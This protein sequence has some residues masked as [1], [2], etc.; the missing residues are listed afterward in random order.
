MRNG[1]LLYDI[2]AIF[3]QINH[4]SC[5]SDMTPSSY[6]SFGYLKKDFRGRHFQD[7]FK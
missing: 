7:D 5:S 4:P 3:Q 6:Y 1:R 2:A